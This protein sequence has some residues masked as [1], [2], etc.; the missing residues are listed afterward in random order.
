[1][2]K[3]TKGTHKHDIPN[4]PFMSPKVSSIPHRCHGSFNNF[5]NCSAAGGFRIGCSYSNSMYVSRTI[6]LQFESPQ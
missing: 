6:K 5:N 2:R 4:C 3:V 1:M